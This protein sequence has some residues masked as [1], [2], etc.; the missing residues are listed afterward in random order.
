MGHQAQ[1][2]FECG[3]PGLEKKKKREREEME[4]MR[5]LSDTVTSGMWHSASTWNIA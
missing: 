2:E 1:I 5:D 3:L 4:T